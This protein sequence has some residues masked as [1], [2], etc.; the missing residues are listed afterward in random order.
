[1]W[2]F[3]IL[4]NLPWILLPFIVAV[5]WNLKLLCDW[6]LKTRLVITPLKFYYR[7]EIFGFRIWSLTFDRT[8]IKMLEL[9]AVSYRKGSKGRI[10]LIPPRINV[11]AGTPQQLAEVGHLSL[12]SLGGNSILNTPELVWVIGILSDYLG[13][14]ITDR[15]IEAKENT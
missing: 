8:D 13:L 14:P 11:W 9:E 5:Y 12:L 10:T 2:L 4:P 15:N 3:G 7:R 6:F 1:M